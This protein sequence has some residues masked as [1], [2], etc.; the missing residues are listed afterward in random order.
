M[1][2]TSAAGSV[3]SWTQE[4]IEL[5]KA[6]VCDAKNWKN[7]WTKWQAGGEH[8]DFDFKHLAIATPLDSGDVEV[9]IPGRKQFG[10]KGLY[11]GAPTHYMQVSA[12][13]FAYCDAMARA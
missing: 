11:A 9:M 2:A 6:G 8:A 4:V 7:T 12:H 1:V 3:Q 5:E 10:A 13:S